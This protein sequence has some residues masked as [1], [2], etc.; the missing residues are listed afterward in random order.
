M[1]DILLEIK[2]IKESPADLKKFGLTIGVVLLLI[3]LILFL[4]N[5]EAIIW[6]I[7]GTVFILSALSFPLLLKPLN[8]IWMTLAIILG[9]IMTRV[10]LSILFFLVLTPLRFIALAFNK[11][12]LDFKIDP[13]AKTY[14][15]KRE[16]N[17]YDPKNYERQ[18]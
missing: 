2:N 16:K 3:A 1:K 17:G 7:I 15:E 6:G 8:K 14:W 5:K 13:S 11:K 4:L 9:W 12:F 10:I 18:F